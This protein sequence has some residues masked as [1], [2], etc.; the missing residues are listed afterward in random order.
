M[1]CADVERN[2]IFG[3]DAAPGHIHHIHHI[4]VAVGGD[5]Q[6]R[7]REQIGI[8]TQFFFHK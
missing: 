2:H 7:H 4:A 3:A 8:D 6:H 5:H 1:V